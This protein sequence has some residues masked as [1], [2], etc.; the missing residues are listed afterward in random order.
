MS[1]VLT[2]ATPVQPTRSAPLV[3]LLAYTQRVGLEPYLDRSAT[4]QAQGYGLKIFP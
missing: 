1:S 3:R 4:G 2:A